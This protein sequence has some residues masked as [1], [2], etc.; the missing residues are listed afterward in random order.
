MLVVVSVQVMVI[1]V[2]VCMVAL[3]LLRGLG[4]TS[5]KHSIISEYTIYTI[6]CTIIC[7][8]EWNMYSGNGDLNTKSKQLKWSEISLTDMV[9]TRLLLVNFLEIRNH[10]YLT[11]PLQ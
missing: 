10:S 9:G 1:D 5:V 8:T 6:V 4:V 7:S 11:H 3:R 2:A